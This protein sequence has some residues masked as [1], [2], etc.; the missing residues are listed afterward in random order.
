M[1]PRDSNT[2]IALGQVLLETPDTAGAVRELEWGV[3]LALES[4]V[5]H[6]SLASAYA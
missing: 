4:P 5:A 3:R 1:C 6:Y 2:H